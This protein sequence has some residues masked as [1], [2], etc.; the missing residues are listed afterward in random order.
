MNIQA[1]NDNLSFIQLGIKL[2][3]RRHFRHFVDGAYCQLVGYITRNGEAD[4]KKLVGNEWVS[5]NFEALAESGEKLTAQNHVKIEHV[6]PL[7]VLG[8]KLLSLVNPSLEDIARFI[9]EEVHYSTITKDE[10]RLLASNG[11]SQKMPVEYYDPSHELYNNPNARYI[12][13]GVEIYRK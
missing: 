10:D 13:A 6:I 1:A 12:K 2:Q 4:W 9:L 8:E 11:L 7:K 5:P 3:N